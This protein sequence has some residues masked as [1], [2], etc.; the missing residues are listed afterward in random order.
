MKTHGMNGTAEYRA[1]ENMKQRCN[2][3]NHPH[4]EKY[5]GRGI[6]ICDKWNNDFIEF[7]K[8][9]GLKPDN[10]Y[11][12][13]RIDVNGNY[14]PGNCRWASKNIQTYNRRKLKGKSSKYIG[15]SYYKHISKW[16]ASIKKN[17][18]TYRS[19]PFLTEGEAYQARLKLEEK[20]APKN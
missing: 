4:Y 14:E 13:D 9:L 6:K 2:N 18:I 16:Y 15:V 5:G 8:D 11:S 7:Y 10:D 3:P 17:G 12:L 20:Y 19:G 1:W